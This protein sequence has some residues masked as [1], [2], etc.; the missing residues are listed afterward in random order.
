[1]T[2]AQRLAVAAMAL[3]TG[4]CAVPQQRGTFAALSTQPAPVFGYQLEGA[5]RTRNVEAEIVTR[6][7]LWVPSRVEP[8]TLAEA[9]DEALR[10]GNGDVLVDAVVD[11]W[12]WYIPLLYGEEGWRV[13]GDVV[14]IPP[15]EPDAMEPAGVSGS[16]P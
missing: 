3:A 11:H 16:M 6:T 12:W 5:P 13:S 14:R 7:I 9:V 10:R 2:A 15:E 1:M 8:P 4:A